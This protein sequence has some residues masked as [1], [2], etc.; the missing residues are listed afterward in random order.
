VRFRHAFNNTVVLWFTN[1]LKTYLEGIATTEDVSE[2]QDYLGN[3]KVFLVVMFF[4]R[5]K[6]DY[7]VD[8]YDG[9]LPIRICAV[10]EGTVVNT[11]NVLLTIESLDP[12]CA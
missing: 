4:D 1:F 7:I 3:E 2:A 11:K 10:P 12:E 8:K 9:K 6:F 5:T